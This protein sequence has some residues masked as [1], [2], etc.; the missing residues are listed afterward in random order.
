L[1]AAIC[2]TQSTPLWTRRPRDRTQ[3]RTRG[4]GA[5]SD[6]ID[7]LL[8]ALVVIDETRR[9]TISRTSDSNFDYRARDVMVAIIDDIHARLKARIG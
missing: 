9:V 4:R 6:S 3:R 7:Q 8:R 2:V 1:T 5:V